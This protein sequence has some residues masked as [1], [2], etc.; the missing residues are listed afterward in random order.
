MEDF[1]NMAPHS[2]PLT[3]SDC[4]LRDFPFMPLD[5]VRLRD[6]DISAKTTADEFRCAVLLWCASWHQVPAASIPED[7][8]VLA[9]LAGFGRVV[10][11]WQKVRQGALHGWVKCSDGR[12]YHPVVAEKA[13]E[14][15]DGRMAYRQRKE[16]E[17]QRKAD[18]RAKKKAATAQQTGAGNPPD[19]PD[20]S[21]GQPAEIPQAGA[22]NPAE[23]ALTGTVDSGQGQWKVERDSQSPKR[24]TRK[25][26]DLG[27]DLGDDL[28]PAS[29]AEWLAFFSHE[30]GIDMGQRRVHDRKKFWPLACAWAQSGVTVGQM[31]TA[32]A[33]A[34][35]E[36]K[37]PIAF[38]PAYVDRVLA[39]QTNKRRPPQPSRHHGIGDTDFQEG[40]SA[41]G[42]F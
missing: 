21:T 34:Q 8:I 42:R 4:D 10:K 31:R 30:H 29:A 19:N 33:K 2:L 6:S 17:R 7:D 18:E 5:V 9:Q 1:E 26:D 40:V 22:G 12:L 38:L 13:I 35:S 25:S 23:N 11:E 24:V 15:W 20:L 36:A 27:N 28:V 37:E 39:S 14:A 41:D 3:P 32:V 16:A